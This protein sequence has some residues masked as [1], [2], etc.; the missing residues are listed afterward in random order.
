MRSRIQALQAQPDFPSIARRWP[1]ALQTGEGIVIPRFEELDGGEALEAI[2]CAGAVGLRPVFEEPVAW[3][4]ARERVLRHVELELGVKL[5]ATP[6]STGWST[7]SLDEE[8]GDFSVW[9]R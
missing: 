9:V 4:E 5:V 7:V 6:T 8:W 3:E 2:I 1:H